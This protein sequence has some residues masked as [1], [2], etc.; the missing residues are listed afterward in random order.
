ML[1][2][3]CGKNEAKVNLVTVVN[4]Q[5]QEIW[6]CEN[7][8]KDIVNIPFFKNVN[9]PF[10]G[11]ITEMLSNID[12]NKTNI[13]NNKIKELV[14]PNC[15]LTYNELKKYG[16]L[17]CPNCYETFKIVLNPQIKS[18]QGEIKHVGKIP[19]IKG[20]QLVQRRKLKDL[21]EEMQKLIITEEYERAAIIRDEIKKLELYILESN[22]N[23]K[24][25]MKEGNCDE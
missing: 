7:C 2:E 3:K 11:M 23:Q 9:L 21:K 20:K 4:G 16:K 15:G 6:L 8:I 5:K 18:L 13:D 17:G 22:V 14:C 12:G 19:K 24:I 25:N 10:Q 1:C